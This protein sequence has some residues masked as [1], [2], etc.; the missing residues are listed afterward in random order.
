MEYISLIVD[1]I[2]GSLAGIGDV[3]EGSRTRGHRA[4]SVKGKHRLRENDTKCPQ[5]PL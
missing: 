1:C 5:H 2:G 4:S 3:S